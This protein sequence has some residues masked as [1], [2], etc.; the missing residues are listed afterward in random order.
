MN[1]NYWGYSYQ[2]TVTKKPKRFTARLVKN[3]HSGVIWYFVAPKT[4]VCWENKHGALFCSSDE[5]IKVGEVYENLTE[6]DSNI[7]EPVE[8]FVAK[9]EAKQ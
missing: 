8:N 4:A 7:Y 1:E 6:C 5:P 9:I 2:V 3:K